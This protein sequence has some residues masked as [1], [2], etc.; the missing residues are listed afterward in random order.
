MQK[1]LDFTFLKNNEY[2]KYDERN[3]NKKFLH[4]SDIKKWIFLHTREV[5]LIKY[6]VNV[7]YEQNG[8]KQFLRPWLILSIIWNMFVVLA[9]TTKPKN[10][11]F[12]YILEDVGTFREK[13]NKST[14]L[15]NQIRAFSRKRFLKKLWMVSEED[16]LKVKK[17]LKDHLNL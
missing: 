1:P 6:G 16:F 3:E 11:T 15:I 13:H 5:R 10:Y 17:L 12:H 9:L 14:I 8:K 7:W 2:L 4:F